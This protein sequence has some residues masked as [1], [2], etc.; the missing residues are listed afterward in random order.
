[1]FKAFIYKGVNYLAIAKVVGSNIDDSNVHIVDVN[2]GNYGAYFS[3][4]NFKEFVDDGNAVIMGKCHLSL[5][6]LD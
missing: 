5:R 2:G 1:M 4:K 6:H 3:I